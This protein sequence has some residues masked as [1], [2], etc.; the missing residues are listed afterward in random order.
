MTLSRRIGITVLATAMAAIIAVIHHH[1][2]PAAAERI[3]LHGTWRIVSRE[4]FG[5]PLPIAPGDQV[6]IDG[7]AMTYS[8]RT[9]P[10]PDWEAPFRLNVRTVPKQFDFRYPIGKGSVPANGWDGL[11][12]AVYERVGSTLRLVWYTNDVA[13]PDSNRRPLK[14]EGEHPAYAMRLTLAR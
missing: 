8:F 10:P 13:N 3:D 9:A 6:V 11:T 14:L 12:R 1:F 2:L 4:H 5:Q 7:V